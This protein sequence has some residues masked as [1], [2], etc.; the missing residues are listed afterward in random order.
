[1]KCGMAKEEKGI[2]LVCGGYDSFIEEFV[3]NI[4]KL[5]EFGYTVILFE[6]PGQGRSL[7]QHLYLIHD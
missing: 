4:S 3:L 6:G 2:I 1:M 7:M 5:T